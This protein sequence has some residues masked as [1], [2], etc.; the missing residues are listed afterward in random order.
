MIDEYIV[1]TDEYVGAGSGAFGLVDGA[2]YANTFSIS[3]Y[4]A[5]LGTA[6]FPLNARKPF[7][8]RELAR[9]TFLMGLFGLRMN[10]N[11]FTAKFGRDLR[12]LLA[13]EYLFFVATGGVRRDSQVLE[14]TEKGRYYWVVMM[15]EFFTG[16]D[17]FRDLSR[18]TA[19]YP[20]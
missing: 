19:G 2:I 17:N 3:D 7:S 12:C 20:R 18:S 6:E 8:R 15:R 16:V 5:R 9:Y 13:L 4:I 11:D 10:L 1:S 14:L